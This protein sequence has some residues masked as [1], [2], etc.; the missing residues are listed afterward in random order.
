M[1]KRF[2]CV[3]SAL[4]VA[5]GLFMLYQP[6]KGEDSAILSENYEAVLQEDGIY[7]RCD[8]ASN[9][10]M[11]RCTNCRTSFEAVGQTGNVIK[12]HGTCP[13]CGYYINI[14]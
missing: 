11:V 5:V 8:G 6:S 14:Q 2:L 12:A 13:V 10:C 7:G 3:L 9:T 1:N 4:L